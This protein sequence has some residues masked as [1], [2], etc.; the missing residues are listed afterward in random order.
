MSQYVASQQT[1]SHYSH[2][3]TC[4][5]NKIREHC[6]CIHGNKLFTFEI[7]KAHTEER[8]NDLNRWNMRIQ[9]G[10]QL[11]ICFDF[12]LF[13]LKLKSKATFSIYPIHVCMRWCKN[14]DISLLSCWVYRWNI[15]EPDD[16]VLFFLLWIDFV[17]QIEFEEMHWTKRIFHLLYIGC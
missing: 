10:I 14:N 11:Y 13:A 1:L 5:N 7:K 8:R 16:W 9:G 2:F 3:Y 12:F 17:S 15:G 4:C 6:I